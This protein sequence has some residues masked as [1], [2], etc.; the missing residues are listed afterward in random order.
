MCISFCFKTYTRPVAA[1]DGMKVNEGE[2]RDM[3]T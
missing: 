1:R 2:N 3:F